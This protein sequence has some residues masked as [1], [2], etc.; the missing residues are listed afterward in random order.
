MAEILNAGVNALRCLDTLCCSEAATADRCDGM[1]R[2][3]YKSLVC[4]G[5]QSYSPRSLQ[6]LDLI[7][8]LQQIID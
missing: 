8:L 5:I 1:F 4:G 7:V 6:R 2:A 3:D